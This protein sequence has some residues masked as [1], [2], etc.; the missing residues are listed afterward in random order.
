IDSS[1]NLAIDYFKVPVENI[2]RDVKP[3][4]FFCPGTLLRVEV[5]TTHPIAYVMDKLATIMFSRSPVFEIS[6]PKEGSLAGKGASTSSPKVVSRYPHISPLM[7]GWILGE[8]T[9][10]NKAALVQADYGKGKLIMFGFRPQNRAQTHGTF[11]LLF[12]SLYYGP[13]QTSQR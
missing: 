12:N 6:K 1:S 4:E 5:D 7:S 10:F 13:A 3:E 11:K 8:K 9:L 2:V